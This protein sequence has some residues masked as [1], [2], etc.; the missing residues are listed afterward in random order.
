[1][2]TFENANVSKEKYNYIGGT[3]YMKK[4]FSKF[5]LIL[6]LMLAI[7]AGCGSTEESNEGNENNEQTEEQTAAFPVT[8]TDDAG[9]EVT[10]EEQPDSIVSLL[11]S[12]T[13]T[14]FALG[15]D[16]EIVGVSDYDNYPAETADIQKV[17]S[18]DLNLEGCNVKIPS[19]VNVV[20]S[21][22]SRPDGTKYWDYIWVV[23][24]AKLN[25]LNTGSF[26]LESFTT[27]EGPW[28]GGRFYLKEFSNLINKTASAMLIFKEKNA[29][30]TSTIDENANGRIIECDKINFDYSDVDPIW[31][32]SFSQTS[33]VKIE[34]N[35]KIRLYPNP[36]KDY[37]NIDLA[38]YNDL[39]K[40]NVYD[41]YGN[42]IRQIRLIDRVDV[43]ELNSGTYFIEFKNNN[44]IYRKSFIVAK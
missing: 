30:V 34:T 35:S 3:T 43:T 12:V 11:P 14:L 16:E 41:V 22:S 31:K 7:L 21:D 5:S 25:Y 38:G 32:D 6:V 17:G 26:F 2:A 23:N 42:L 33:D 13:E 37:I 20:Y 9:N 36:S 27:L 29:S 4:S 15:L 8:I 28:L 10:I 19:T 1:M 18:M 39:E 40:L 44:S 24:G